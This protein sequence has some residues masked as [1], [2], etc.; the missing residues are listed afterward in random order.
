MIPIAKASKK[1]NIIADIFGGLLHLN[2]KQIKLTRLNFKQAY[3][4][5]N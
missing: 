5:Y 2:F 3:F 1:G 4:A